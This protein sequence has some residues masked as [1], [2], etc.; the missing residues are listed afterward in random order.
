MCV[1]LF[2]NPNGRCKNNDQ[3]ADDAKD[4]GEP[5]EVPRPSFPELSKGSM[6]KSDVFVEQQSND[7]ECLDGFQKDY[8][9]EIRKGSSK[10]EET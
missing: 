6:S 2:L 7:I 8:F 1:K 10:V 3:K 9:V 4:V 5:V